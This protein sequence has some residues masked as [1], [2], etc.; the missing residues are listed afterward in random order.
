LDEII[1]FRRLTRAQMDKIVEI[2]VQRLMKLLADRKITLTL[3]AKAK[4]WLAQA[5]Y[6]PVF[7]ARPL[8]RVIQRSLQDP[9]AQFILEGQIEDGA[10][11]KVSAGKRGLIINGMEFATDIDDIGLRGEP[12]HPS[13]AVH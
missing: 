2:Q 13:H 9:L 7:G 8:K 3:D 10:V 12:G 4:T 11:V 1:L 6:D 5:G